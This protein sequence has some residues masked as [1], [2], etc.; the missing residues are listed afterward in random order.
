MSAQLQHHIVVHCAHAGPA[1]EKHATRSTSVMQFR[2][3]WLTHCHYLCGDG[4]LP[5]SKEPA[6]QLPA[7]HSSLQLHSGCLHAQVG[8]PLHPPV[9]TLL[10]HC[11]CS[12]LLCNDLA[13]RAAPLHFLDTDCHLLELHTHATSSQIPLHCC[14][15]P[16]PQFCKLDAAVACCGIGTRTEHP[17][18]SL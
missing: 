7:A 5:D 2:A 13:H 8:A 17:R 4:S 9:P 1:D 14:M 15:H 18:C 6:T 3:S 10:H 16:G 11:C 12:C